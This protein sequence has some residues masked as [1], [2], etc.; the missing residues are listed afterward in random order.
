M[1]TTLRYDENSISVERLDSTISHKACVNCRSKKLKCS[2]HRDGCQRCYDAGLACEYLKR[3]R[4]VIRAAPAESRSPNGNLAFVAPANDC[5]ES[6]VRNPWYTQTKC[7]KITYTAQHGVNPQPT[8][9]STNFRHGLI[10]GYLHQTDFPIMA[11]RS[12]DQEVNKYL[13]RNDEGVVLPDLCCG[14]TIHLP[15]EKDLPDIPN[16][17]ACTSTNGVDIQRSHETEQPRPDRTSLTEGNQHLTRLV[18]PGLIQT[19]QIECNCLKS[20]LCTSEALDVECRRL[21]LNSVDSLLRV[22]KLGLARIRDTLE[23]YS[24]ILNSSTKMLVTMMCRTMMSSFEVLFDIL[25]AQY[26]R[27]QLLGKPRNSNSSLSG[28]NRTSEVAHDRDVGP[29]STMGLV[30]LKQYEL[31]A[32]EEPCVFGGLA[33]MQMQTLGRLI[34]QL[35]VLCETPP[36]VLHS[37]ILKGIQKRG[38]Y[39]L[40]VLRKYHDIHPQSC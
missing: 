21:C 3:Q 7:A 26:E 24:C 34:D 13:D 36:Q 4:N 2:G 1:F 9:P 12:G 5:T 16:D 23:C 22:T 29:V 28:H 10:E 19:D 18:S 32:F 37:E 8:S 11:S 31:D 27:L 35:I 14:F 6:D 40:A 15:S 38:Q 30:V 20:L 17:L 25:T 33:T 39:Q